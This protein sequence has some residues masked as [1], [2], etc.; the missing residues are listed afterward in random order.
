V[1]FNY[2][3]Q[4]VYTDRQ[5]HTTT[6]RTTDLIISSNVHFVP[7]ADI[8]MSAKW[9]RIVHRLW[10]YELKIDTLHRERSQL[11]TNCFTSFRFRERTYVRNDECMDGQIG[12]QTWQAR[13]A[14]RSINEDGLMIINRPR[15]IDL[16]YLL[17]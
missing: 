14:L 4:F 10:H 3:R 17:I 12:G 1:P 15:P 8:I 7:L 5:T 6:Y 11:H 2:L 13:S 9:R 16:Q